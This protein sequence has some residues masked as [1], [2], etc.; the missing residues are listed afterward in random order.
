MKTWTM[1]VIVGCVVCVLDEKSMANERVVKEDRFGKKS[2][3][4]LQTM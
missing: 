3:P 4:L 1:G 2:P